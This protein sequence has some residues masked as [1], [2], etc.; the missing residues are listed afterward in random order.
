VVGD[1]VRGST[2][3]RDL[4]VDGDPKKGRR[5]EITC[6]HCQAPQTRTSAQ[7]NFALRKGFPIACPRCVAEGRV[8]RSCEYADII[9][10]RVLDGGPF[11]TIGEVA[12][13]CKDVLSELEAEF[14]PMS[15]RDDELLPRD[16]EIGAG[17]PYSSGDIQEAR[18]GLKKFLAAP[19]VDLEW[20]QLMARERA[21]AEEREYQEA[22]ERATEA[23]K[24][25]MKK[26]DRDIRI[27]LTQHHL[28]GEKRFRER[29]N[30]AAEAL[31]DF[32]GAG[33]SIEES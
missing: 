33:G 5:F 28:R 22:L 19:K 6:G 18:E 27:A 1:S 26:K 32:V 15:R 9:A 14:G 16:M 25:Q 29:A 3:L 13:M 23:A 10:E 24:K 12:L 21:Q 17:F 30:V 31:A 20:I 4:G 11:Y 7:I 2:V 8:V